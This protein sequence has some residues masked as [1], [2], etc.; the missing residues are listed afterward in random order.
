MLNILSA[1]AGLIRRNSFINGQGRVLAAVVV[2]V[3]AAFVVAVAVAAAFVAVVTVAAAAVSLIVPAGTAHSEGTF[4]IVAVAAGFDMH[5]LTWQ[6][7][8]NMR[9][10]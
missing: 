10:L 8:Y 5:F 4:D 7:Y 1:C 2:A 6:E 9:G 3:V